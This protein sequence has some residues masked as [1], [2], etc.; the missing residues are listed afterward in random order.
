LRGNLEETPVINQIGLD[1]SGGVAH[2]CLFYPDM[3]YLKPQTTKFM[4]CART[5]ATMIDASIN[6]FILSWK[7]GN[8]LW[9][10]LKYLYDD[11]NSIRDQNDRRLTPS[12]RS[13]NANSLVCI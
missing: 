13:S 5:D 11:C 3:L 2:Q 9:H 7:L 1:G 12:A 6:Y 10:V 4:S 8:Q